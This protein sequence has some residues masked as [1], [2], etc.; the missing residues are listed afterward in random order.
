MSRNESSAAWLASL[1]V[2]GIPLVAWLLFFRDPAAYAHS[3]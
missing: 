2:L 1:F 3:V